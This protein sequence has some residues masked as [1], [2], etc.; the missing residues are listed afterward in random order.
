MYFTQKICTTFFDK[1]NEK[2][3]SLLMTG[4]MVIMPV[5][6]SVQAKGIEE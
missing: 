4:A 5:T 2:T 6:M 1:N 3:V